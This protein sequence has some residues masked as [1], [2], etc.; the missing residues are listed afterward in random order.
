MPCHAGHF[1]WRA[2]PGEVDLAWAIRLKTPSPS[3]NALCIPGVITEAST[4]P[5][6]SPPS[7]DALGSDS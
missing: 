1:D 3:R 2:E 6:V 7:A 5:A 4:M